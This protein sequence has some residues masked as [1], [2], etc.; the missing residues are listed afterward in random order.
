MSFVDRE[1]R[2]HSGWVVRTVELNGPK[3]TLWIVLDE[4][5]GQMFEVMVDRRPLLRR[6][7]DELKEALLRS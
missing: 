5:D 4:K 6:L 7:L 3:T 1:G 2:D